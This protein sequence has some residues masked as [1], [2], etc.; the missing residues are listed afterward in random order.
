MKDI[1]EMLLQRDKFHLD[2]TN[3]IA[4]E[5]QYVFKAI[6]T[7]LDEQPE[8]I[9]WHSMEFSSEEDAVMFSART[10]EKD[11]FSLFS[12]G[13]PLEVILKGTEEAI[14]GFLEQSNREEREKRETAELAAR[15]KL[16]SRVKQ[17]I[18]GDENAV[19]MVP[20]TKSIEDVP[21]LTGADVIREANT[22]KRTLH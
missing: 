11:G 20:I 10:R 6:L 12:V 14:I 19:I 17:A 4:L 13:V 15:E 3:S 7:F 8:N 22:K 5:I 1:R 18:E 16:T 2:A 9:E 21:E